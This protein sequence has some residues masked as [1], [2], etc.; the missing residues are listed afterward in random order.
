MRAVKN[1]EAT[2]SEVMMMPYPTREE[3]LKMSGDDLNRLLNNCLLPIFGERAMGT[4]ERDIYY[5]LLDATEAKAY[6]RHLGFRFK[7]AE[8]ATGS[9]AAFAREVRDGTPYQ[10]TGELCEAAATARAAAITLFDAELLMTVSAVATESNFY[11]TVESGSIPLVKL[12][13]RKRR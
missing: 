12:N 5:N 3:I 8:L 4:H 9:A 13:D 1:Q 2:S 7:Y 6:L 11:T 10:S